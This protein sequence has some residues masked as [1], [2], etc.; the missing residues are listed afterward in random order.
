MWI[1]YGTTFFNKMHIF[2]MSFVYEKF[3]GNALDAIIFKIRVWIIEYY[4]FTCFIYNQ[5]FR[6]MFFESHLSIQYASPFFALLNNLIW[7][8]N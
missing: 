5:I 1:D 3:V 7:Q 2:L 4:I 8:K 6:D